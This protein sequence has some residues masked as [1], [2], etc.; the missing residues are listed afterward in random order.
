MRQPVLL[1]PS[2]AGDVE[3]IAVVLAAIIRRIDEER[4][5]AQSRDLPPSIDR[6]PGGARRGAAG[7][8]FLLAV[9]RALVDMGVGIV[10]R[11][12]PA[13][14]TLGRLYDFVAQPGNTI[15][16]PGSRRLQLRRSRD[17]FGFRSVAALR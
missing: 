1:E 9:H 5:H 3:P 4:R 17:R 8:R 10:Y 13:G 6:A 12:A 11:A 14:T 7:M 16:A 2:M 15:S